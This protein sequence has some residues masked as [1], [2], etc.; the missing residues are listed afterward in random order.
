M[1]KKNVLVH[2][3][4]LEEFRVTTGDPR[5]IL[6]RYMLSLPNFTHV[7]PTRS[8]KPLLQLNDKNSLIFNCDVN[9][10]KR[11]LQLPSLRRFKRNPASPLVIIP[12]VLRS[13]G[14]CKTEDT[15]RHMNLLVFNTN[16]SELERIDIKKY[17]LDGYGLKIFVKRSSEAV[18]PVLKKIYNVEDISVVPDLDPQFSFVEAVGV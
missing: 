1:T 8:K 13:A 14:K 11:Q 12:V 10:N 3:N 18:W 2:V 15:A 17:H 7:F 4:E 16:T 5:P 6:L 9:T